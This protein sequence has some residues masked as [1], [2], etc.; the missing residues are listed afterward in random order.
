MGW[1]WGARLAVHQHR[2]VEHVKPNKR[3]VAG[4]SLLMALRLGGCNGEQDA[5]TAP[6]TPGSPAQ[7][8]Q[9]VTPQT[10]LVCER[11]EVVYRRPLR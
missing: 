2:K 7:Q 5:A 11:F 6:T 8:S 9:A 10:P 1:T 4:A 3:T